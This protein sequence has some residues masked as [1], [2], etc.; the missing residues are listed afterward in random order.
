MQR[1]CGNPCEGG[2]VTVQRR[3]GHHAEEVWSPCR[4]GVVNMLRCGQHAKEVWSPCR[5]GVVIM[6]YRYGHHAMQEVW[7]TCR[8]GVVTSLTVPCT[9]CSRGSDSESTQSRRDA[10]AC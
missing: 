2:V 3:C 4:G 6:P 8:G 9:L 7:S 1:K 5:G 10:S